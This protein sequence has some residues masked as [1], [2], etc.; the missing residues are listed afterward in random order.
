M[1]LHCAGTC[2]QLQYAAFQLC[3][4]TCCAIDLKRHVL[5]DAMRAGPARPVPTYIPVLLTPA[6]PSHSSMF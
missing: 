5:Q 3:A 4:V 2:S 1:Y 6:H